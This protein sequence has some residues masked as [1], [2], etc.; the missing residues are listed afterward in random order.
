MFGIEIRMGKSQPRRPGLESVQCPGTRL[1]HAPRG[2]PHV[3]Y[4]ALEVIACDPIHPTPRD[5]VQEYTIQIR[6][7]PYRMRDGRGNEVNRPQLFDT[8]WVGLVNP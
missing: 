1:S 2:S 8:S 7:D 6:W 5:Q 3:Q 4:I